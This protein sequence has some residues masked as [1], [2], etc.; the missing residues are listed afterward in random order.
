MFDTNLNRGLLFV[1]RVAQGAQQQNVNQ[2][3]QF[4]NVRQILAADGALG[5]LHAD[6]EA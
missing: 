5:D 2:M 3:P 6:D 1:H 4:R